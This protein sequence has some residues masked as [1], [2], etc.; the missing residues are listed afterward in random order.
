GGPATRASM[1]APHSVWEGPDGSIHITEYG[2]HRVRKIDPSGI[3]TTIAGQ[4]R[5]GYSGDGGRGVN[6][7]VERPTAITTNAAGDVF[8]CDSANNI[9]RKIDRNGIIT[10]VAGMPNQG[11]RP[12]S[13]V[14]VPATRAQMFWPE[15]L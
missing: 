6:A 1:N 11:E 14:N 7:L 3:I 12:F 8:F 4:G 13:G 2:A 5:G 10:T 15:G 9:V